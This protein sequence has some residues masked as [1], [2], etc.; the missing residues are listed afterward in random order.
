MGFPGL[1]KSRAV[2]HKFF[3]LPKAPQDHLLSDTETAEDQVEDVIVGG[4]AGDFVEWTEG[5]IEIKQEHFMRDAVVDRG[6]GIGEGG[7]RVVHER[8]VAGVG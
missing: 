1:F 8:L 4:R 3:G 5:V 7:Q 6:F 2:R